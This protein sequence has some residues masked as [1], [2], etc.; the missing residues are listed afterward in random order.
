[1][2]EE[3]VVEEASALADFDEKYKDTY[4][5]HMTVCKATRKDPAVIDKLTQ[6]ITGAAPAIHHV[7]EADVYS[8]DPSRPVE[9]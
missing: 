8:T 5:N 4:A 1:M 7:P 3:M 2:F 6:F 9:L